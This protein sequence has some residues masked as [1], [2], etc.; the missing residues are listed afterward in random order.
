MVM[1]SQSISFSIY[2]VFISYMSSNVGSNIVLNSV[3]QLEAVLHT[4]GYFTDTALKA[5][6]FSWPLPFVS[7][8]CQDLLL[9]RKADHKCAGDVGFLPNAQYFL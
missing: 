2:I 8:P 7:C 3:V 6:L 5:R 9:G 4:E 1:I